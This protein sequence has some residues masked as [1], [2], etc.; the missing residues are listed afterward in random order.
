MDAV[1]ARVEEARRQGLTVTADMYTYTAG[2]TSLAACI[3]PWAHA[4]GQEALLKR[5][6]EPETRRRIDAE[7]REPGKGWENLCHLT[8]SPER[9]LL[10]DFGPEAM[11]PLTGKTLAE[12]AGMRGRDSVS[13]AI[14]LVIEARA[15]VGAVY[16]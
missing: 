11:K 8:G 10:V 2:A 7:M 1:I 12:V 16:S 5:L 3:P 13:T 9:V 4:G 15:L 6:Q 14:D